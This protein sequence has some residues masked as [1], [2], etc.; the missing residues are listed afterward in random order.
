MFFPATTTKARHWNTLKMN[1][2]R[3]GKKNMIQNHPNK[4]NKIQVEMK[5]PVR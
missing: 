1:Q 5:P 3:K 4:A 2:A